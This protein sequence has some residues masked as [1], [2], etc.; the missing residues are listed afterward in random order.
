MAGFPSGG[1]LS[2]SAAFPLRFNKVLT[3]VGNL[4][5]GN[6]SSENNFDDDI[7][8][9]NANVWFGYYSHKYIAFG[10]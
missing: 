6:S 4:Y 10:L 5:E 9:N 8:Y 1:K 7:T 3:V 2:R